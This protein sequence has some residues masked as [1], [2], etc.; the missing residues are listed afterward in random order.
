MSDGSSG[1]DKGMIDVTHLSLR[2]LDDID[3]AERERAFRQALDRA[4]RNGD[5][6]SSD[7]QQPEFED[8]PL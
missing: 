5:A 1:A 6:T 8:H 4:V 2:Q 3:D 7:S